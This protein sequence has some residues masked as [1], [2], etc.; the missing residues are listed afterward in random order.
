MWREVARNGFARGQVLLNGLFWTDSPRHAVKSPGAESFAF[1]I[2]YE[3]TFAKYSP[4]VSGDTG[5][6]GAPAR[7]LRVLPGS[8][9][10][11]NTTIA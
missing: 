10:V 9:R 6:S 7:R 4:G 8:I 2:A 11:R 3:E 1:K 5:S